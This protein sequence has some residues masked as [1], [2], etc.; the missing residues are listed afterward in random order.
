VSELP[1]VASPGEARPAGLSHDWVARDGRPVRLRALQPSDLEL[2]LAFV[3]GLS[4]STRYLRLQYATRGMSRE[5][6]ERLLELDH[7]NRLAIAGVAGRDGVER[8][9]G[10]CRYAREPDERSA[11]FAI[12][13]ADDWQGS[14]L[15]T[16]LMRSLCLAARARGVQRLVG[17][18]LATNRRFIDWARSFGFTVEVE[19]HTGLARATLDLDGPKAPQ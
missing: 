11:E 19:P 2:E 12:V 7:V 9:V 10:V 4:P 15:G 3:E 1:P 8:I 13:V 16:E 18:T 17:E 6:A 5:M 14:G